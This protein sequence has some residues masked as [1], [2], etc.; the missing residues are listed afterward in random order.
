MELRD[1][2][3][4]LAAG[5]NLAV[6]RNGKAYLIT[7]LNP[8]K[9]RNSVECE[10]LDTAKGGA[11][12]PETVLALVG[13]W[14]TLRQPGKA[15]PPV[16]RPF[17]RPLLS[18]LLNRHSLPVL[19]TSFVVFPVFFA[20][21][22]TLGAKFLIDYCGLKADSAALILMLTI[23][24]WAA[25]GL[26]A[27]PLQKL[28]RQ[29]RKPIL[30]VGLSLGFAAT[31]FMIWG[32]LSHA[33]AGLYLV[34]F[35]LLAVA[36]SVTMPV[37]SG[38]IMKELN[39]PEVVSQSIAVSNVA[40]YLGVAVLSNVCGLVLDRFAGQAVQTSVGLV[41]PGWAYAI[42]FIILAALMLIA[43]IAAFFVHETRGKSRH[44]GLRR[45]GAL[46]SW[47]GM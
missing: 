4:G 46:K 3:N 34:C 38:A 29:R 10:T 1:I 15:P 37:G 27:G 13:T 40:T 44:R 43:L 23:S 35:A 2:Q 20:I 30:L 42:N 39:D 32:A 47:G 9:P 31:L 19:I 11:C 21:Q 45:L 28:T 8:A 17:L 25:V 36:A 33:H 14:L 16:R 18:I 26:L 41:Y 5:K 12:A 6:L 7:G 24:V 22:A